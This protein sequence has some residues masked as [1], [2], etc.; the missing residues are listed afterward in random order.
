M[1]DIGIMGGTF[2]P[3]RSRELLIAQS[4]L[5]QHHLDKVLLM[6]N[7]N[8]PHK[9]SDAS[10]ELLPAEKRWEMV[11]ASVK[12]NNQLE[13]S[14][15]EIDR[16]GVTWSIDTL[17][18]LKE[19]FGEVVRLNF[20]CG[21]DTVKSLERYDRRA[22][23]LSLCR[24]LVAPRDVAHANLLSDWRATL[25][26]AQIEQIDVPA[27]SSSSTMV[28]EWI[29]AGRSVKYL[30]PRG[31]YSILRRKKHYQDKRKAA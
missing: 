4:A 12:D 13:A 8:P 9:R 18:E 28:R 17:K 23:F 1:I 10:Y 22:E 27:D 7:G 2:N 11:A 15:M 16:P 30:V 14:R 31:A 21:A 5:D 3:I 19:R 25:P 20:I 29:A 6:T 24:L 26:E